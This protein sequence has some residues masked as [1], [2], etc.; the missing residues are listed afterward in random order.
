MPYL[1]LLCMHVFQSILLAV[2]ILKT[3]KL[4]LVA[5]VIRDP[6][7]ASGRRVLTTPLYT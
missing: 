4:T 2:M 3:F 5:V 6:C 1:K 7:K